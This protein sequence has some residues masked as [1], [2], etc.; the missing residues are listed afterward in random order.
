MLLKFCL[1]HYFALFLWSVN[2]TDRT[3]TW[4]RN[5]MLAVLCRAAVSFTAEVTSKAVR[6]SMASQFGFSDSQHSDYLEIIHY[7]DSW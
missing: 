6:T 7:S 1:V 5:A 4:V 2:H 3:V